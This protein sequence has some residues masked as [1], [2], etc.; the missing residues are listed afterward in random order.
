MKKFLS[1][2]LFC[3][4]WVISDGFG[5][6]SYSLKAEM[7]RLRFNTNTVDVNPG[8]N[9]KGHN[10][11]G[12]NGLDINAQN[13]I[14]YRDKLYAGVGIGYLNFEGYEGVSVFF[15]VEY[16][17]LK[18]RLSPLANL[19]IGQTHIWNQ[20]E[21]GT[22]TAM[23]EFAFGMNYRIRE[24]FSLYAKTGILFTQQSSLTPLQLG[25]RFF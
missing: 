12:Q 13:G 9:W 22:R 16:V 6:V 2:I 19:R 8:P 24:S 1:L 5:Q 23:A 7:G 25:I 21:D 20:Y 15:D 10:L 4:F 3:F 17:P 18:T 14:S 11:E